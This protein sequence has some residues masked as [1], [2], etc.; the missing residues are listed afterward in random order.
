MPRQISH[1]QGDWSE[2][3]KPWDDDKRNR[4]LKNMDLYREVER[5]EA[6]VK[7]S[8]GS[9]FSKANY[10]KALSAWRKAAQAKK[11][12]DIGDK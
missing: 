12:E 11:N 10:E 3:M 6:E 4:A 1:F 8:R 5:A 7:S 9:G 2:D